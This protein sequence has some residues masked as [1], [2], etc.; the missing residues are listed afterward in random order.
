MELSSGLSQAMVDVEKYHALM[1]MDTA[2]LESRADEL[3]SKQ[4]SL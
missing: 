2:T 3:G 1:E 4:T